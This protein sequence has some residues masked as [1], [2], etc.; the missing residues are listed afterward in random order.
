MKHDGSLEHCPF[1]RTALPAPAS[2]YGEAQCPQCEGQLWYL[3]LAS[4]S[5][6]FIRRAAESIYDLMASLAGPRYG[7]TAQDLEITLRDADSLDVVEFVA[8][9]EDALRS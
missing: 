1:C 7:F 5:T 9:L 2:A 4:G 3:G 6:F 8:T